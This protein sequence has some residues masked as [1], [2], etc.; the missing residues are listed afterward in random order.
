MCTSV[1]YSSSCQGSGSSTSG[2]SLVLILAART[3]QCSL[4][5]L[6]G[7][8]PETRRNVRAS[9]ERAPGS[10]TLS[11][12][13][14]RCWCCWACMFVVSANGC[15]MVGEKTMVSQWAHYP[16]WRSALKWR[17]QGTPPRL[18]AAVLAGL[19]EGGRDG[20]CRGQRNDC[21]PKQAKCLDSSGI[22]NVTA[23]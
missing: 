23:S 15:M 5:W 12:G 3:R 2:R 11:G 4:A 17:S 8:P 1:S 21:I 7:G 14:S 6:G 22:I 19:L 16:A 13:A 9:G 18:C 10:G 20:F